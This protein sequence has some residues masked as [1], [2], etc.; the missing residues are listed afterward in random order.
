[1]TQQ[2]NLA[3]AFLR[4][5]TAVNTLSDRT[6]NLASLTT[7]DKT[8]I[9][10]ALN[11]L[12]S[13]IPTSAASINDT[14]TS[15][16]TTWSSSKINGQINAAITALLGGVDGASDTLKELAD[17]ILALSQADA[18]LLSFTASQTLTT[19]QKQQGCA[20]LGIGD[21]E[22]NY[23]TAIEAGLNAGL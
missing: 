13:L 19:G 7:T 9:V 14:G 1:M 6:G 20:N 17:Q 2:T 22:H 11:E 21:P 5:T 18:G 23:V 8:S 4:L 16:T 12:K 15:T 10:A 3:A